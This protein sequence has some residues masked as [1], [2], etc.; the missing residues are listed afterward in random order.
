MSTLI[1]YDNIF[2]AEECEKVKSFGLRRGQ[3][4]IIF[5]LVG[6]QLMYYLLSIVDRDGF[7]FC[8]GNAGGSSCQISLLPFF[9]RGVNLIGI[10][11]ENCIVDKSKIWA[12][13]FSTISIEQLLKINTRLDFFDL[14]ISLEEILTSRL[15]TCTHFFFSFN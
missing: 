15:N 7:Y 11:S 8:I 2:I 4:D 3:F 12:F 13:I 14:P 6:G 9:E 5:D 10:N 1:N